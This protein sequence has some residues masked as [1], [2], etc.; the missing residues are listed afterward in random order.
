[1]PRTILVVFAHPSYRRSRSGRILAEAV[2]GLAG[3][4]FH[5]LYETYP[6]GDIDLEAEKQRL[7]EH[8]VIVLQHPFYWY[9]VPPLLKEW[10][11]LVLEFGWAYGPGGEA[12]RG[13]GWMAAITTGGGAEAYTRQGPNRYTIRE[14]LAPIEQTGRLCGMEWLG[15]FVVH[16]SHRL[17][18]TEL[19]QHA[20]DYRRLLEALRDER[21]DPRRADELTHLNAD[22]DAVVREG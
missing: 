2:G 15:P 21:F 13:K 18:D 3:C 19:R 1:M 11:D 9:S 16:G 8:D 7:R 10:I 5:D 14:L 12:L 20:V 4:S 22:L 17:T 6:D